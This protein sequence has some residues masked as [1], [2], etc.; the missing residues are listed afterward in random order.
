M[1][2]T[3]KNPQDHLPVYPLLPGT[4]RHTAQ[5]SAVHT[6]SRF[7]DQ[8]GARFALG[9]RQTH[10]YPSA[11]PLPKCFIPPAIDLPLL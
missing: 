10:A 2:N 5:Q 1:H 9:A 3:A 8:A 4:Y 6:R 7:F 11:K